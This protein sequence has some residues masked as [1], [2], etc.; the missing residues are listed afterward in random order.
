PRRRQTIQSRKRDFKVRSGRWDMAKEMPERA[1]LDYHIGRCKAPCIGLQTQAEY[2]AMI[3][4]VILFLDGHAKEVIRRVRERMEAASGQLDFERA[5]EMRDMLGALEKMEEPS[6]I[7]EVEGGDRDVLGYAR[8]GD[9][10]CVVMLRIR[11]GRLVAREH[12]YLANLEGEG[13]PAVLAAY[14]ARVYRTLDGRAPEL[15]APFDFE[16]REVIGESLPGTE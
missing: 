8:D 7:V 14:I 11:N 2:R 12:Q 13:E 3:D 9:E 1:C 4:E 5:A 6:V 16:D 10:A 15:L